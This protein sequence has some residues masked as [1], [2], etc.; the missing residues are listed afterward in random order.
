MD[1]L[2]NK[3]TLDE[4][5]NNY[6]V[7][8][9][10]NQQPALFLRCAQQC[11]KIISAYKGTF[12]ED[13]AQLNLLLWMI[14][15]NLISVKDCLVAMGN[16]VMYMCD[17]FDEKYKAPKIFI[18]H[19]T[20]DNLIVEKFVTM[21]EQ[22]GVKQGQLFCSSVAGH[23]I[24]QG[25]GDIYDFI[26][27]EMSNDNLFVIMML[28]KNYY[29]SPACLNEM[30][31]AWIKQSAYQSILLPGFQYSQ[32]EGAVN[33]R[34]MAFCLADKKNRKYA[35]N[36]LKDRIICHLGLDNITQSLWERFRDTFLE[37][38]DCISES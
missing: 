36:D 20:N 35:L 23:G 18:S 33:P 15:H 34:D 25:S 26:C 21:L 28:S 22:L 31:A 9:L 29:K 6:I 3:E 4:F 12:T 30:G 5:Y 2:V 24:P 32:I 14:K 16:V 13:C 27:D 10:N 19:S 7:L 8:T 17:H 37:E 1:C 38:T 11:Q